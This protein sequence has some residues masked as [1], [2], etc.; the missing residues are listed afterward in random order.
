VRDAGI[1]AVIGGEG[2]DEL[3]GGYSFA[4]G[5]L[6]ESRRPRSPLAALARFVRPRRHPPASIGAT[7]PLLARLAAALRIPAPII[8]TAD[9]LAGV[10]R[11]LLA[12][13]FVEQQR[14]ADPYRRLL[15]D[16]RV[17]ELIGRDPFK[18]VMSLW[19]RTHFANYLMAAE[20]LDMAHA[21]EVRLPFTDH[22]LFERIREL[23]IKHLR[24]G[25]RNKDLLRRIA[26]PYVTRRVLE[27]QKRPFLAPPGTPGDP[28]FAHI[29]SIL[30]DR[31]FRDVAFFEFAAVQRFLDGFGALTVTRRREQAPLLFV[32]ASCAVLH[33]WLARQRKPATQL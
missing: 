5:A 20:R 26:A 33:R 12:P 22:V 18:I 6:G 29:E 10:H 30:R 13:A 14:H 17:R 25:N 8:A 3:F 16:F 15:R 4:Q 9:S 28:L 19:L 7:S 24:R 31:T 1:K 23:P 2:A 27:S 32:L 11:G 21:V